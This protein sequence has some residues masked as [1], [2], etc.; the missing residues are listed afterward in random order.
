M[1]VITVN[2]N[3][4]GRIV[5][6]VTFQPN[7]V[8]SLTN[9]GPLHIRVLRTATNSTGFYVPVLFDAVRNGAQDPNGTSVGV[10]DN[11]GCRVETLFDMEGRTFI[12]D[13]IMTEISANPPAIYTTAQSE[14]WLNDGQINDAARRVNFEDSNVILTNQQV[15]I[16]TAESPDTFVP[17]R[18]IV[19]LENVIFDRNILHQSESPDRDPADNKM[20]FWTPY[21]RNLTDFTTLA[22]W[23][24]VTFEGNAGR[25]GT[26]GGSTRQ[27]GND[28]LGI[29]Q[30]QFT[31]FRP[32]S[33]L[34]N[35]T[36][37][38]NA[39][40]RVPAHIKTFNFRPS[41]NA[42][43]LHLENRGNYPN[44]D[45]AG[46]YP[47]LTK[48]GLVLSD[49]SDFQ[50][51]EANYTRSRFVDAASVSGGTRYG[52]T[53]GYSLF[54]RPNMIDFCSDG[55]YNFDNNT[56]LFGLG[57]T[58]RDPDN[59][60][61]RISG[62][63]VMMERNH[64]SIWVSP[65]MGNMASNPVVRENQPE[66]NFPNAL[67]FGGVVSGDS[68]ISSA[69]TNISAVSQMA[70]FKPVFLN[71]DQTEASDV[72]LHF[73][74]VDDEND[75]NVLLARNFF[76]NRGIPVSGGNTY[77][78]VIPRE[79]WAFTGFLEVG[80]DVDSS[81]GSY[82]IQNQTPDALPSEFDVP[83]NHLLVELKYIDFTESEITQLRPNRPR[84]EFEPYQFNG[85]DIT[86]SNIKY[87]AKS[88]ASDSDFEYY[89]PMQEVTVPHQVLTVSNGQQRI[90]DEDITTYYPGSQIVDDQNVNSTIIELGDDL[91]N[92]LI[93]STRSEATP[94]HDGA[95]SLGSELFTGPVDV[96]DWYR[97]LRNY[98]WIFWSNTQNNNDF[99]LTPTTEGVLAEGVTGDDIILITSASSG[100]TGI[101]L[102]GEFY[103]SL[104]TGVVNNIPTIRRGVGSNAGNV[105]PGLYDW[106]FLTRV[107]MAFD[108]TA[109]FL[110][111][112]I[113]MRFFDSVFT[114]G[115]GS[116]LTINGVHGGASVETRNVN[117]L[118]RGGGATLPI[119]TT[120]GVSLTGPRIDTGGAPISGTTFTLT[121]HSTTARPENLVAHQ[122]VINESTFIGVPQSGT[123]T[124]IV[125]FGSANLFPTFTGTNRFRDVQVRLSV[126]DGTSSLIGGQFLFEDGVYLR[127]A[128]AYNNIASDTD[129]D[130]I[131]TIYFE[132]V[133]DD[134]MVGLRNYTF[135]GEQQSGRPI[136]NIINPDTTRNL[137]LDHTGIPSDSI[138]IL[139]TDPLTGNA[140]GRFSDLTAGINTQ[141]KPDGAITIFYDTETGNEI[142]RI[143]PGPVDEVSIP[144]SRQFVLAFTYFPEHIPTFKVIGTSRTLSYDDLI[145]DQNLVGAPDA[146]QAFLFGLTSEA[147]VNADGNELIVTT[148]G[149]TD[150]ALLQAAI[151]DATVRSSQEHGTVIVAD[152]RRRRMVGLIPP[153]AENFNGRSQNDQNIYDELTPQLNFEADFYM[154]TSDGFRIGPDPDGSSSQS[155]AV[156]PR[157]QVFP[158]GYFTSFTIEGRPTFTNFELREVTA[159]T[160]T[161]SRSVVAIPLFD[162]SGSP[163]TSTTQFVADTIDLHLLSTETDT[164]PSVSTGPILLL[165]EDPFVVEQGTNHVFL[166]AS[167]VLLSARLVSNGRPIAA[168]NRAI[169]TTSG[170]GPTVTQFNNYLTSNTVG[171]DITLNDTERAESFAVVRGTFLTS[172]AFDYTILAELQRINRSIANDS[173]VGIRPRT[174]TG[175]TDNT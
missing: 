162:E 127:G 79:D 158:D 123:S 105:F 4:R 135:L 29:L 166:N 24:G 76:Y 83:V 120:D 163:I 84:N 155:Y 125:Q 60:D 108:G 12:C 145:I 15:G 113:N 77:T 94:Q 131:P 27:S 67:R 71:S 36:L 25:W 128:A 146:T 118:L 103:A 119:G 98:W 17:Y 72:K 150:N 75:R 154:R 117:L 90:E 167:V 34:D 116:D 160:T 19:E 41:I 86:Q 126:P 168:L 95:L 175:L 9:G 33:T 20:H 14:P 172:S 97:A 5:P 18:G 55:A 110:I 46:G 11:G 85:D 87:V 153:P 49:G 73:S 141:G 130:N 26:S 96:D 57:P 35:I 170:T 104:R 115:A 157:S 109:P 149:F 23:D 111:D 136:V 80:I 48:G 122:G 99:P 151:L 102:G 139:T 65:L 82:A 3:L 121:S 144:G 13:R 62:R 156:W 1:S 112:G 143:G 30:L 173:L 152:Y 44:S 10:I 142:T 7:T 21:A 174:H 92:Y 129:H 8:S 50:D 59:F 114:N 32:E 2:P 69:G 43:T 78:R 133:P 63:S 140:A 51:N 45:S 132:N 81:T 164:T 28:P 124:S 169:G 88:Y 47:L 100:R 38:N 134:N 93:T 137:I 68:A 40:A 161:D 42:D 52:I 6:S 22:R 147:A 138:N 39:S 70:A 31:G 165:R 61:S 16:P 107:D 54:M 89:L 64:Y 56:I 106:T 66:P 37:V 148:T 74:R 101:P 91:S 58:P 159:V 171:Y 53:G